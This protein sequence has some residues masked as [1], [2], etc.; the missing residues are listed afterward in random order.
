MTHT[1]NSPSG[2]RE[3]VLSS[4]TSVN[5]GLRY[6]KGANTTGTLGCHIVF[7]KNTGAVLVGSFASTDQ[8]KFWPN[9]D[10]SINYPRVHPTGGLQ[11]VQAVGTF[12]PLTPPTRSVVYQVVADCWNTN[13]GQSYDIPVAQ[14]TVNGFWVYPTE[15]ANFLFH[16][17]EF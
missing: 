4:F 11:L 7:K 1:L 10:S 2:S 9:I 5:L 8:V 14:R 15:N 6:N 12:I 16:I 13:G 3:F 17:I